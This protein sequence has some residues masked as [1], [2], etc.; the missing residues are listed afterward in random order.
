MR[1]FSAY[2]IYSGHFHNQY[3]PVSLNQSGHFSLTSLISKAFL[4]AEL[5]LSGCLQ[6]V[7]HENPKK[8][9]SETLKPTAMPVTEITYNL[10]LCWM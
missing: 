1:G 8:S 2:H 9:V 5:L 6:A 4:L 7:V 10:F 3:L